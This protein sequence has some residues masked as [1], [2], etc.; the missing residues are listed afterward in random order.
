M[1][2][3]KRGPLALELWAKQLIDGYRGVSVRNMTTSWRNGLAFCALIHR[4]RPD[5]I[6]YDKLDPSDIIG[7][8]ALAF[9]T[10]ESKLGIPALLDPEDMANLEVP[11]RLSV[12]T[13]VAQFYNA[14]KNAEVKSRVL[15]RTG[16]DEDNLK[17]LSGD[18]SKSPSPE[19]EDS[20]EMM[21]QYKPEIFC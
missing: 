7:N 2:R 10:A 1:G 19:K 15:P 18:K 4:F 17:N 8:C 21:G 14:F 11:D 9:D 3:E 12:L 16:D 20:V 6:D 5:L 13:Y